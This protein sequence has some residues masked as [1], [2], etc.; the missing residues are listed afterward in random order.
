MIDID[1]IDW[2]GYAL[3]YLFGAITVLIV[4]LVVGR[5]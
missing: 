4:L 5:I 2:K 3:A 1:M